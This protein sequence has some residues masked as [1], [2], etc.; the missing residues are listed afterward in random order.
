MRILFFLL[1]TFS[2]L[3]QVTTEEIFPTGDKE[4]TLIFDLKLAKDS[5]ASGLLGKTS[6]VYLWSGAGDADPGDAFK[7]QPAGQTNFSAPFDKGKMTSLGNDKWS[8]KLTPRT[9]FNVPAGNPI[10]KLG[11]LLKSGD[12]KAQTE[13]FILKLYAGSYALK[14]LSPTES[15]TLAEA[16]TSVNVRAKFSATSSISLKSA[17]TVLTSSASSDSINYTYSLGAEKGKLHTLILEGTSGSSSLK[18]SVRILTKPLVVTEALPSGIKDGVNYVGNKVVLCF[19]APSTSFVY[20]IGEFSNWAALPAFLMK[21]TAD[22][23]RYW[24]DLGAQEAGKEVAYQYWV[25]G[26][27]AV[28]DPLTEKILDPS[29]DGSIPATTYPALK[30]YPTGAKGIVSVFESGA[31]PY[32]WKT[33]SFTRPASS[34]LHVYELLVRDFVA[35]R[36]YKT[37]ADSLGYLKKLGINS[38]ELMPVAEFSGNDSWGYNP[39]FYT[40]PDKAYGTKNDL[41]YLIDKCHENGMAVIMDIVLNQADYENPYVKMYWD[42]SKPTTTSPFFNPAATHPYSVF[43]D[44]NHEST[45]TQWLVDVVTKFWLEEYK[46]DGYRFDLSKGFTQTPSGSNVDLWGQY[47]ASRVKIWKRIY[48]KIRSY[49]PTAYVVLEHFAAN[50]EENELGNYGMLLWG[51]SKF[52]MARIAQGYTQDLSNASYKMRGFTNPSVMNYI[53]SHDEERLMVE[54]TNGGKKVFT[55]QEKLERMKMAAATFFTIPGPK[56]IWQ[57]GELGY[58]VSINDNGR[59]GAKPL[60]WSYVQDSERAKLLKVY[61][62][63]GALKTSKSIFT[64]TD[65]TVGSIGAVKRN[66]LTKGADYVLVLANPDI[67]SQVV[68]AS[69]PKTG[70]WYDYFSGKSFEVK[71]AEAKMNLLPG[72]F[73]LLTNVAW[74]TANLNLV[75]WSTPDFNIMGVESAT[76]NMKVYPN[77]SQD[78]VQLDWEAEMATETTLRVLDVAGREV[79][80]KTLPQTKGMNSTTVSTQNI[81]K[82]LYFIQLN[83]SKAKLVVQ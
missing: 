34:N 83:N 41:K 15:F 78:V 5:R 56:M 35:D 36:R 9:Y 38:L 29:N 18:D 70:V 47:D 49:D 79:L 81:P 20:A 21:R 19:Y 7:Y 14:W 33:T 50:N 64:T 1:F 44:F 80:Q 27:L 46:I 69:F 40:A 73:H 22:G 77:P 17:G 39:I 72:E 13:D 54:V 60:K 10:I 68:S 6:D 61:Q 42:G 26:K 30:T 28:A 59:T 23:L 4:I 65:F 31:T 11:L 12:G 71:D 74:N 75:P 48:D 3:A 82:G 24:I 63:L 43:F 8:I 45:H 76:I 51:N 32:V 58:D 62:Q 2:A 53:E 52:D 66:L 55:A 67:N 25:D 16:G 57:F 37:V